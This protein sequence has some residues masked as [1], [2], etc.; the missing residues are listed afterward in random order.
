MYRH[1]AVVRDDRLSWLRRLFQR[2][3]QIAL[4]LSRAGGCAIGKIQFGTF[5]RGGVAGSLL[6]ALLIMLWASRAG[7]DSFAPSGGSRCARSRWQ[8][9]R[10]QR[11]RHRYRRAR[12]F[13]RDKGLAAGL[14][15]GGLTRSAVGT[16]SSAISQLGLTAGEV[17][18]L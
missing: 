8:R 2:S 12:M 7:R 1:G 16:A 14:A 13:G 3:P 10:Y 5:Q 11:P 4:L 9:R 6:F 17:Q 15:A 18:R